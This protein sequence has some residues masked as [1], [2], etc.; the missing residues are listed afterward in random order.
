[1]REVTEDVRVPDQAFGGDRIPVPAILGGMAFTP[2]ERVD[3]GGPP[4]LQRWASR[5]GIGAGSAKAPYTRSAG[6]NAP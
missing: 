4:V 5:V 2:G 6:W 3:R 1:M